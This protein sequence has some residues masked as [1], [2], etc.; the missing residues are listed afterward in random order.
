MLS[1]YGIF[2]GV[3]EH[4]SFTRTAEKLGY[5]QSAVSQAVRAL[6]LETETV[7]IDRRKDGITLTP[8]GEQYLPYFQQIHQA[9]QNLE[10]KEQ[11]MKGLKNSVVRIGTFTIQISGSSCSRENTP[12]LPGGWKKE[13]WILDLPMQKQ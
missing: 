7:L 6:E 3:I 2:C 9:E 1:R 10:R 13:V 11:E 8:D 4:K 5:S 12:A